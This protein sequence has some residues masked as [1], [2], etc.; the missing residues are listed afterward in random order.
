MIRPIPEREWGRATELACLYGVSRVVLPLLKGT[1]RDI[2]QGLRLLF[3]L[4]R[5]TGYISQTLS[6]AGEQATS[7][8]LS[9]T[10]AAADP[11]RG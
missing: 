9:F 7:S 8:N 2:Q 10:G 5:S 6:A 3:G 11:G 4:Q 1:V